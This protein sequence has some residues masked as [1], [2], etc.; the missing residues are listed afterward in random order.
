MYYDFSGKFNIAR[1]TDNRQQLDNFIKQNNLIAFLNLILNKNLTEKQINRIYD[2]TIFMLDQRHKESLK[3]IRSLLIT[4]DKVFLEKS[5]PSHSHLKLDDFSFY[6]LYACISNPILPHDKAFRTY[7]NLF[8]YAPKKYKDAVDELLNIP[9]FKTKYFEYDWARNT[10]SDSTKEDELL[11]VLKRFD[12]R[13]LVDMVIDNPNVTDRVLDYIRKNFDSPGVQLS[14]YK[15][16][17]KKKGQDFALVNK[18]ENPRSVYTDD[19][20]LLLHNREIEKKDRAKK[21][22]NLPRPAAVVKAGTSIRRPDTSINRDAKLARHLMRR[23]Y[24]LLLN[25]KLFKNEEY[26][27]NMPGFTDKNSRLIRSALD[28][29]LEKAVREIWYNRNFGL[30][31]DKWY[32]PIKNE[33]LVKAGFF[34]F[35][36]FEM[37][38]FYRCKVFLAN[39][40]HLFFDIVEGTKP[41]DNLWL[42]ALYTYILCAISDMVSGNSLPPE[43]PRLPGSGKDKRGRPKSVYKSQNTKYLPRKLTR[44]KKGKGEGKRS[45][46]GG[47][48]PWHFRRINR[49]PSSE[50]IQKALLYG[51]LTIPEGSTFVSPHW[52]GKSSIE[53]RIVTNRLTS[54]F[55]YT[56][57]KL[58]SN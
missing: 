37:R 18:R 33:V 31:G 16:D 20:Y 2:S 36:A 53:K 5:V 40:K 51:I 21:A 11:D 14:L 26:F 13:V 47:F 44:Y 19:A 46:E 4:D 43:R 45:Y 23:F 54:S 32:S 57:D 58:F 17:L 9:I 42:Y 22:A 35:T 15:L 10:A 29:Y 28:V 30:P 38:K 25:Y 8:L 49:P 6:E 39:K 41:P 24:Y 1:T 3:K 12:Y 55:S 52:R 50:A 34:Y 48:V 27:L 56:L 7:R